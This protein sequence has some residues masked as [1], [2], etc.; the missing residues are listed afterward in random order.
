MFRKNI[1]VSIFKEIEFGPSIISYHN[2]KINYFIIKNYEK[3]KF[4]LQTTSSNRRY[5][6][7]NYINEIDKQNLPQIID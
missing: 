7:Y 2:D 1:K 4:T 3:F 6:Y 5:Y